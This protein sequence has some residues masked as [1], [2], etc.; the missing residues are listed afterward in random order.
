MTTQNTSGTVFACND[1]DLAAFLWAGRA[2]FLGIEPSPTRKNPNQV[3]FRFHDPDGWCRTQ[4][5]E[6]ELGAEISA[7]QY[8]CALKQLKDQLFRYILR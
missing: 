5:T 2:R 8:A 3:V 7:R 4:Q 6:Y 1:L